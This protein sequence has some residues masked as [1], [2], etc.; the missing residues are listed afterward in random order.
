MAQLLKNVDLILDEHMYNCK[1]F[2]FASVFIPDFETYSDNYRKAV[3][4]DKACAWWIDIIP[5]G[6]K[7]SVYVFEDRSSIDKFKTDF[8]NIIN[9]IN[10][11][12]G[13]NP[14]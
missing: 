9:Q 11:C 1:A 3:S 7:C 10:F 6:F 8:S 14:N 5:N 13:S 12:Y 2:M 4:K